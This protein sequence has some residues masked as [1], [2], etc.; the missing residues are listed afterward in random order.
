VRGLEGIRVLE[1]GELVSAAF[2]TKMMGDLGADVVK[3]ETPE[4]DRARRRGPFPRALDGAAPDPEQ[5]GLFLALNSNKRGVTLDLDARADRGRFEDLVA[6][7]DILVHNL[8]AARISQLGIDYERLRAIRESLVVCSIAP[9]GLTGP[10]RDYRA[11]ELTVQHGGGWSFLSPG[12]SEFPDLPP[13]KA[14]GHQADFQAAIAAN[15]AT[16]AALYRARETGQGEHVD[17]SVQAYVASFIEVALVYWTYPG[18]LA[19]RIGARGLNPWGIYQCR[20]GLIFV[21]TPE[22]DQWQR[23]IEFMGSPEWASLEIFEG[24]AN[25]FKNADALRIFMQEWIGEW[26]V[27]ELFHAGQKQR[28]CFAPVLSMEEFGSQPQLRERD[29]FVPV[30]H[31]R[32]G[33][34]E[35]IG[36]PYRLRD[37]WWQVSRPAPLLGEHQDEVLAEW[38]VV[39]GAEPSVVP[40]PSRQDGSANKGASGLPLEG[41]R[42]LDLSW[43]WAG[44]FGAMHLAHLGAEVIKVESVGRPD[45]GRRL[46]VFAKDAHEGDG[47]GINHSGYFNQWNQGKKSIRL[48]LAH[49]EALAIVKQL[50]AHCDVLIE[51]FASGVMERLGLDYDSLLEYRPDLIMASISGYGETGPWR[52]YM[53][54]GPAISPLSGLSSMSGYEGEGPSEVGISLGDPAAGITA[55]SAVCAALLARQRSGRGQ[56][57]DISLWEATAV[58]SVEG[59]M[60]QQLRGEQPARMANRDPQMC[61]HGVFRCQG[62]DD[63]VTIACATEDEWRALCG[64]VDPALAEDGRFGGEADRKQNEDALDARIEAWTSTRDRWDVTRALQAVGVAAF[65]SMSARDLAEDAH[66]AAQGFF[67]ELPHPVVGA[68]KHAGIPWRLHNGPNG[69]RAPAPCLGADTEDVLGELLGYTADRVRELAEKKVVY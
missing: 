64:V 8:P 17:L 11:E 16:L 26:Q 61:P 29:F 20:D 38:A 62:D 52:E 1:L 34:F 41:C 57:I 14:F 25:R 5:S 31:P 36:A 43:V 39:P 28:I 30:T 2:A 18:S 9:F 21:A 45:L 3:I 66:L 68:R 50:V 53:G 48:S 40:A 69:V 23:L 13:L 37:P 19:G 10:H 54:Y 47:P 59:W 7:A 49:P 33:T 6:S 44:P 46:P 22:E 35:A 67:E 27:D 58:G 65:P 63:W 60:Y 15:A 32:A 12:A 42:V 24:F 56:H 4:G 55:T 51:N